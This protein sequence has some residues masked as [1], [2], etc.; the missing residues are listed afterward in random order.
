MGLGRGGTERAMQNFS[1][2]YRRL[3]HQVAVLALM[4]G[5]PRRENLEREGISVIVGGSDLEPALRAAEAFAPDIIHI[6]RVGIAN[7][8]QTAVLR[9]LRT[10]NRRVLETNVFGRVDE[11]DGAQHIDVHMHLS[12]WCLWRW[13]RWLGRSGQD[14]IGVV[15]PNP[16]TAE[17]FSRAS[18]AAIRAFRGRWNIPADAFVCGRVGQPDPS[19]WDVATL[20]AFAKLASLYP[21]AHLLV[22]GMPETFRLKVAAMPADTRRRIIEL[23]VT[24]VDEELALLYSSLD[25]FLHAAPIG[26]TFG[27]VLA[28]AMLCQCPV[29]TASTPHDSNS[30]VEVVGHMIGGIVARSMADLPQAAVCLWRDRS[31]AERLKPQLRQHVLSR[32][33][34]DLV[35]QT[36]ISVATLALDSPDRAALRK[37]LAQS[38]IPHQVSDEQVLGL[39]NRTVGKP[40]LREMIEMR[41]RH[42][43]AV[44]RVIDA[45][46]ARTLERIERG[47]VQT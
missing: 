14:R 31:L 23:P 19:K 25:C 16:V 34:S 20:K 38:D 29:V 5:G 27:Y 11:S 41:L 12:A 9:R 13:R 3:G 21:D 22:L 33:E 45:R 39:L 30:Q 17:G 10:P 36:A 40:R 42:L 35:A 4:D 18:P 26:E 28:E 2:S 7:G 37:K 1:I 47:R 44:R 8:M 15:V 46:I 43:V 32:Y 24:D 6:H